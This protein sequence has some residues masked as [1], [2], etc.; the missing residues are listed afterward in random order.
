LSQH[1]EDIRK[2]IS[3]S[4]LRFVSLERVRALFE[5]LGLVDL[6][7][8]DDEFLNFL[9]Q[10]TMANLIQ[11]DP[12][13][14]ALRIVEPTL[15][16]LFLRLYELQARDALGHAHQQAAQFFTERI[17]HS[18]ELFSIYLPELIYHRLMYARLVDEGLA[19]T[20]PAQLMDDL[21]K[22]DTLPGTKEWCKVLDSISHDP[23]LPMLAPQPAW[24]SVLAMLEQNCSAS[25]THKQDPVGGTAWQPM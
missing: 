19:E 21:G 1:A 9:H 14:K 22:L 11:R 15:R 13:N 24:Q 2:I 12:N 5:R 25:D 17:Q 8:G 7:L 20:L 3:M 23:D 18:H 10:L 16:C 4:V 6:G